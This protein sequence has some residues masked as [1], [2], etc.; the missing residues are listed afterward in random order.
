VATT[1][2][3]ELARFSAQLEKE[4]A[5]ALTLVGVVYRKIALETLRGIVL[6]TPVLTGRARGN[7]QLTI[8]SP[9]GGTIDGVDPEGG[10]TIEAGAAVVAQ[11]FGFPE[12]WIAN[13]LGYIE[14]LEDGYSR[15]APD[16]M[17][18]ITL[19]DIASRFEGVTVEG[20]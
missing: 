9:A 7:W 16:G 1:S 2:A 10:A 15:K 20:E 3:A 11:M 19:E 12:V 17:V 8:S 6:A 5:A 18:M 14:R 4:G 13:N